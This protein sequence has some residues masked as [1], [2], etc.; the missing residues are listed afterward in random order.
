MPLH[1][2]ALRTAI[3]VDRLDLH[4]LTVRAAR[5]RV[6]D[7]LATAQRQHAGAVVRI[8]TGAG[9]RSDGPA[10]LRPMVE[11][12]LGSPAVSHAIEAWRRDVDGG[13]YLVRLR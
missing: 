3:V 5:S 11:Q 6:V 1:G 8:I 7:F 13:S 9:H 2:G 4:G 12:L 10:R